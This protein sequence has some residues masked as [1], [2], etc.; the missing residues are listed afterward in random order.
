MVNERT[1]ELRQSISILQQNVTNSKLAEERLRKS[2]E[3]FKLI[4]EN[5]ADLIMVMNTEGV[6]EYF[7]PSV[8]TTL[9]RELGSSPASSVFDW[10]HPEDR[11]RCIASV[12][13]C[14]NNADCQFLELRFQHK[15][16]GWRHQEARIC[17]IRE[18]AD[19]RPHLVL[20]GRDL[21][22]KKEME[23]QTTFLTRKLLA[24][25]EAGDKASA[26]AAHPKESA[27][28]SISKQIQRVQ[29]EVKKLKPLLHEQQRIVEKAAAEIDDEIVELKSE[30]PKVI[31]ESLANV[32][33]I[34]KMITD[35]K[36]SADQ[37]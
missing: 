14:I 17:A 18:K 25:E 20:V 37:G 5:A 19:D 9:G 29:E 35:L 7:S 4:T 13:A 15:N 11:E 3:R 24:A 31:T 33:T 22:E 12:S 1:S 34:S 27:L 28:K 21:S 32:D 30:L 10:V 23:S 2:E 16:G 26:S 6:P 36:Q 8:K